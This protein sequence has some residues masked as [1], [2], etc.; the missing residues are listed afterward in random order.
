MPE[1]IRVVSAAIYRYFAD[2]VR[3]LLLTQRSPDTSYPFHWVT[4]GG[5]VEPS[6]SG[7]ETLVRELFEE[8]GNDA[9]IIAH[10]KR[11]WIEVYSHDLSSTRRG[12]L[13][14]IDC[15]GVQALDDAVFVPRDKT[16]GV[17]WFDAEALRAVKLGPADDANREALISVLT[18]R[19][20]R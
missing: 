8:C 11:P 10:R 14:H 12:A 16:I 2:G 7:S 13:V 20:G 15:Y 5:K 9:A 17:G 1:T 3:R 6:E 4:P 19:G 18:L